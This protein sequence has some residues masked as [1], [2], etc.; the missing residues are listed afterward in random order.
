[1]LSLEDFLDAEI[2]AFESPEYQAELEQSSV[3]RR[4]NILFKRLLFDYDE[5]LSIALQAFIKSDGKEP[6]WPDL[7]SIYPELKYVVAEPPTP[8]NIAGIVLQEITL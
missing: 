8:V 3:A 1:M 7:I 4:N 2:E 5:E 6:L